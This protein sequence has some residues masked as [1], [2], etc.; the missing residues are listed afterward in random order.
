MDADVT[1]LECSNNKCYAS[2]FIYIYM[3]NLESN[4]ISPLKKKN[5]IR[6]KLFHFCTQ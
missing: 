3:H 6:F 5:L 1:Q 2:A 4:W